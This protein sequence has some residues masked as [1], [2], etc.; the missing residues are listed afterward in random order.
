MFNCKDAP[1]QTELEVLEI[2]PTFGI[3]FTVKVVDVCTALTQPVFIVL[4]LKL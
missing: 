2:V 1:T 4:I 3:V